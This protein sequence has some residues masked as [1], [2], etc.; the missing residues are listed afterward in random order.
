MKI[1][2]L[3]AWV[4]GILIVCL[5]ARIHGYANQNDCFPKYNAPISSEMLVFPFLFYFV[6]KQLKTNYIICQKNL[7]AKSLKN[8][9]KK[10][11]RIMPF[12]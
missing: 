8:L 1:V 7:L 10:Y 9:E 2:K 12:Q 4:V 11:F 5:P 3:I 6:L